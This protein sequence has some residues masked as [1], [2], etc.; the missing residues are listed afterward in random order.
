M[1]AVIGATELEIKNFK[2]MYK[3][4]F[5][6]G[7]GLTNTSYNLTKL[8]YTN[9]RKFEKIFMFGIGGGFKNRVNLLDICVASEEINGDFGICFENKVETLENNRIF[10]K[11]S[12][13]DLKFLKCKTG[14]FITVN[15]VTI[16]KK[17]IGF[18]E[19]NYSPICE[20]MEGYAAALICKCEKIQFYEI[21]V[22]SNFVG[23]RENWKVKEAIEILYET[24]KEIIKNFI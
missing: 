21:R 15:C 23:E 5:V 16:N 6:T 9:K 14:P 4:T 18:Y 3:N 22:I 13:N 8:I 19:K 10:L 7:I 2:Q 1:I 20:N 24:G 11:D 17:R 12:C